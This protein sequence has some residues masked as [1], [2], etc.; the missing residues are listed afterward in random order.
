MAALV[1][2]Q[3]PDDLHRRLKNDAVRH[4]RSMTQQAIVIL[5]SA[6]GPVSHIPPARPVKLGVPLT[7]AFINRAKREGRE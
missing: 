4:H 3:L 2:K 1:I 7:N 5:E 6:L